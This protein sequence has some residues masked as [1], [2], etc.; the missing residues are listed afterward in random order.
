MAAPTTGLTIVKRFTYR[1]DASEEWSNH[2]WLSGTTPADAAAWRALF[3]ALVLQEKTCYKT[4][5][6]VVAGY[7]YNSVADGATA[8]WSVDMD[9]A[10]NTP[11]N[12]TLTSGSGYPMMGDAAGWVRWGLDRFNSKGKRIYLRKY[13]H[14]G[15]IVGSGPDQFAAETNTAYTA[16]GNK[17]RDGTFAGSRV[18]TDR[19][20]AAVINSGISPFSTTRT[21]KRRG[22]RPP[23]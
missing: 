13:F 6:K 9:I 17:M 12:G 10:P 20:G 8:V 15:F 19:T 21:L 5:S 3:D 1:G 7:G 11:V 14:D 2:Y 22:K 23:S 18:I 4:T 16:F